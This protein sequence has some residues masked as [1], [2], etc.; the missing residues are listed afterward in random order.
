MSHFLAVHIM[1]SPT[2]RDPGE[3]EVQTLSKGLCH[4]PFSDV[5]TAIF[6]SQTE[7]FA[8]PEQSFGNAIPPFSPL[9]LRKPPL[10]SQPLRASVPHTQIG[11]ISSSRWVQARKVKAKYT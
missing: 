8:I 3:Y 4:L 1:V 7:R 2:Y 10:Y 5:S 6:D 11:S 9:W